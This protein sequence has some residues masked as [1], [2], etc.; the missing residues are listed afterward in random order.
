[1]SGVVSG[2]VDVDTSLRADGADANTAS[3][4]MVFP[5]IADSTFWTTVTHPSAPPLRLKAFILNV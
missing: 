4:I 2:D 1:M 5:K 3:T